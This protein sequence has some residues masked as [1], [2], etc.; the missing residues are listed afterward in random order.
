MYEVALQRLNVSCEQILVVGDRV[1]TDIAGAQRIGCHTAL[2]L[3]G[4]TNAEQAAKWNPP[5]DI[6]TADLESL[7]NMPWG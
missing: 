7:V 3:S 6:I 5:P 2:V 4:V 1:E